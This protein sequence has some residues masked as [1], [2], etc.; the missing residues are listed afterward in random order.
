MTE[1]R[2]ADGIDVAGLVEDAFLDL[3]AIFEDSDWR[4]FVFL[5]GYSM[6]VNGDVR[7]HEVTLER[8]LEYGIEAWRWADRCACE[9]TILGPNG[10]DRVVAAR[11]GFHRK[12]L[13]NAPFV[14]PEPGPLAPACRK[15]ATAGEGDS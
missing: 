5:T 8:A 1:G 14:R 4:K 10:L 2:T 11:E 7:R 6:S 3:E 12:G 13:G 15:P 9:S